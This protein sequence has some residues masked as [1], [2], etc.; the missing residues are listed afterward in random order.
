[1]VMATK[2]SIEWKLPVLIGGVVFA[3]SAALLW[4]SWVEVQQAVRGAATDRVAS[5]A[6]QLADML[7]TS[8]GQL[9]S[10]AR[11]TADAG[12]IR[13]FMRTRSPSRTTR[14]SALRAMQYTG[15]Q[16]GQ[17]V[18]VALYRT[19]GVHV[20]DLASTGQPTAPELRPRD[21]ARGASADSG[22]VGTLYALNDSTIVYPVIAP[23]LADTLRL[24]EVV[25][26]RNLAVS[27]RARD[28]IARLIGSGAA[29]FIGSRDGGAWTDLSR[30]VPA[31][32]ASV[33]ARPGIVQYGQ[34]GAGR[35]L[36][37]VVAVRGAPWLAVLDFPLSAVLEPARSFLGRFLEIAAVLIPL[38]CA[39]GWAMSRRITLPLR[40][41]TRS[42]DAISAGNF[43]ERVHVVRTDELG[44]L[45]V[46]FNRMAARI[47]SSQRRSE[48]LLRE[49]IEATTDYSIIAL[50]PNGCVATWNAGAE[51][52]KGY[53][54]AEIIGRPFALFYAPEDI[55][56]H[57][58]DR[59]LAKAAAEGRAEDEGWRVRSD[60]TRFWANVVITAI[61]NSD[62]ALIGFGKVTRDLTARREIEVELARSNT[63]LERFSYSVAHDLR[64]PLRA[65]N[66]FA[67][68]VSEDYAAALDG[69]GLRLLG[70]V[71]DNATQMGHLIDA[72]LNFSR[73]GRQAIKPERVDMQ[74]LAESVGRALGAG[75]PGEAPAIIVGGLPPAVA[76]ATLIRQVLTN[77]LQNAL[78][79]SRNRGDR[80]IEVGG[81]R[82]GDQGLYF[83]KDNGI[84]FDMAYGDRLFGVFSRLHR[85]EDFEGTGIGLAL[86]HRI[87]LRHGGEVWADGVVDGGATFWF[88]LPTTPEAA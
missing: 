8:V 20:L 51:R 22:I 85:S 32:P 18:S 57:R 72:L 64:A 61:R 14:E 68:A 42:A 29:F 67:Q 83:V 26:W 24:G 75:E 44:Q 71:R 48:A 45:A 9:T 87:I 30:V 16:P 49:M 66:G 81:E 53:R 69:E 21:L 52:I 40:E 41:L 82:R 35:E 3:V 25:Q 38:A 46:A 60:G 78:K 84:G 74:A 86:V 2:R 56:D 39:A 1:M 54:A 36:G 11:I 79:F 33:T 88:T 70:V 10:G 43:A 23:V 15:P 28:Q 34:S 62:G 47:E 6:Q 37:C 27:A 77:L 7:S 12:A 65:I 73:V 19:D 55:M 76:D 17:V 31:P 13:D 58:P 4:T 5:V 80:R 63:E 59:L 50:D